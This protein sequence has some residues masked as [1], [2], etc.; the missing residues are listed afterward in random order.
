MTKKIEL[1]KKYRTR[2]G[3]GVRIY[4]VD[5][6]GD[7]PVHGATLHPTEGWLGHWWKS[8][9]KSSD[10]SED[11]CD[12]IEVKPRIKREVWMNVYNSMFTVAT[13]KT[14]ED[15][16]QHATAGRIACIPITIDCE[17]GEGLE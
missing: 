11:N 5:G 13:Y 8:N 16:D 4:A 12:L 10:F 17:E 15:A 14:K 1:G 7:R 3:R 2:D 6:G 9:G